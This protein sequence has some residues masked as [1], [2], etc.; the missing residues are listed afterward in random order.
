[1][2]MAVV[3]IGG[4]VWALDIWVCAALFIGAA[5]ELGALESGSSL[6]I[7]LVGTGIYAGLWRC[8]TVMQ[9]ECYCGY[10]DKEEH[11]GYSPLFKGGG[12]KL[13]AL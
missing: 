7:F 6:H 3:S 5:A 1:M 8:P 2:A 12:D 13:G 11:G 9:K 4:G 10:G